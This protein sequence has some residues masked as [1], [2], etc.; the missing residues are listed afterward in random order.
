MY[1]DEGPSFG[2]VVF[3]EHH[4]YFQKSAHVHL[5]VVQ[6]WKCDCCFRRSVRV[7]YTSL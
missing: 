4:E 7:P 5:N 3:A 2:I 6:I 1:R